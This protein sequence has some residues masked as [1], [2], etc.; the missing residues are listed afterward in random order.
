MGGVGCRGKGG[1]VRLCFV[2]ARS[3]RIKTGECVQSK[4]EMKK[5]EG[6]NIL[7]VAV[8]VAW[9]STALDNLT[10]AAGTTEE[11][12]VGSLWP[13][14]G[15]LVE[16][17]DGSTSLD[18]SGTCCLCEVQG[19]HFEG[20]DFQGAEVVSDGSHHNGNLVSSVLEALDEGLE[21]DGDFVGAA[22]V[23][24]LQ[25]HLVETRGDTSVQVFVELDQQSKVGVVAPDLAGD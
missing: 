23:K 4:K 1:R 11:D 15:E 19:A 13:L 6:S 10:A 12:G 8:L 5:E 2:V 17:V 7:D 14:N 18:D 25:D 24:A 21:G 20:G 16:G 3:T 22:V 9:D